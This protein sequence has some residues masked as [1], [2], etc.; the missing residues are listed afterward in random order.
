[1]MPLQER[2]RGRWTSIL[3]A[4]GIGREYLTGKNGPCP[5]CPGGRDRWRF[6]NKAGSGSWIC[7][8]CGAGQGVKLAMQFTGMPF[9]ELARK[10][11]R[12]ISSAPIEPARRERSDAERRDA[13]NRLW[14]SGSPVRADDPVDRWLTARGLAMRSPPRSIRCAMR[15]RHSGP[16]VSWH[17]AMVAMVSDADGKPATI[18]KTYIT[19]N[20]AKAAVDQVRMFCP[21]PRPVGGAVRLA[22][23][24]DVL[25]VAEGIETA[26]AA[27]KLF[28][29]PTW[30]ALDAS[31]VEKFVPPANLKRLV[32]F[33]DHDAHGA[34]QRAA[35][36]LAARLAGRL[37]IEVRI[38]DEAGADWN[39]IL[40]RGR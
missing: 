4:L 29:I 25:G 39:D 2:A 3:P 34:G 10:I 40:L 28:G 32:I 5:L 30:A 11:D 19:T 9:D 7:T 13:L 17:P 27:A 12:I 21:G 23:V 16:P 33:G 35:Y 24:D 1:M 37:E 8:H 38:P 36:A 18:H 20:G 14:C 26:L 22:P 31:G 6:D 15:A